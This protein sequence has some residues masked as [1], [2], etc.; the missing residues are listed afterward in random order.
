MQTSSFSRDRGRFIENQVVECAYVAQVRPYPVFEAGHESQRALFD[1]R[2]K[3]RR[4]PRGQ[5]RGFVN[6]EFLQWFPHPPLREFRNPHLA[7]MRAVESSGARPGILDEGQSVPRSIIGAR[8]HQTP[9]DPRRH[10]LGHRVTDQRPSQRCAP[11]GFSGPGPIGA[12]SLQSF[13][14]ADI[15]SDYFTV[16]Q[17]DRRGRRN[18]DRRSILQRRNAIRPPTQ[19]TGAF[20]PVESMGMSI[21]PSI[22]LDRHGFVDQQDVR[23]ITIIA[24]K[25]KHPLPSLRQKGQRVHDSIGPPVPSRLELRNESSHGAAFIQAQ[26]E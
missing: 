25:K 17:E 24:G 10:R 20:G 4:S 21:Q 16:R 2:Q 18:S 5:Q 9:P 23:W 8:P 26:H 11:Y 19:S 14:I 12:E 6:Q 13:R 15:R 1:S 3:T 22:H 7:T